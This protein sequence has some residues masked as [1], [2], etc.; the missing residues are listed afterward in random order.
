MKIHSIEI[1]FREVL[2]C[3]IAGSIFVF[4][5]FILDSYLIA[6]DQN[7]L[8]RMNRAII[9]SNIEEFKHGIDT[10]IGDVFSPFE[11]ESYNGSYSIQFSEIAVFP[12]TVL[13]SFIV[14]RMPVYCPL[15]V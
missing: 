10:N 7:D 12:F 1:T 3:V 6:K 4:L 15:D 9:L 5:F 11:L 8:S 13:S 14:Q 2:F